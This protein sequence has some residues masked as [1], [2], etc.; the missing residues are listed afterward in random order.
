MEQARG[1]LYTYKLVDRKKI[2]YPEVRV[3]VDCGFNVW[4]SVAVG[5]PEE[6]DESG[7]IRTVK[8][9]GVYSLEEGGNDRNILY[10]YRC[11]IEEVIDGDTVW[12]IIDL[13]FDTIVR[14]KL[15]L[16]GI[17]APDT[18]ASHRYGQEG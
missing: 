12:A 9:K 13:G 14:Q 7:I 6:F 15:R 11:M 10:C 16:R 17:D 3:I 5:N 18:G 2:S 1:T 4:R 8:R